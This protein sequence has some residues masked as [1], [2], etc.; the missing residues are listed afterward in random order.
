MTINKCFHYGKESLAQYIFMTGEWIFSE[1]LFKK[2][3]KL[4]KKVNV[5][6]QFFIKSLVKIK[7]LRKK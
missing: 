6:I 4:G 2:G 5:V 7:K 1:D 3:K